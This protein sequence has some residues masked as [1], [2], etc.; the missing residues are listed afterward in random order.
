MILSFFRK[1]FSR[2]YDDD[3]YTGEFSARGERE[4][5]GILEFENGQRYHFYAKSACAATLVYA[6]AQQRSRLIFPSRIH[7]AHESALRAHVRV[8]VR[9]RVM[10]GT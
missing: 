10:V 7:R 8:F 1:N 6:R 9:A 4:G 5:K 2:P 3:Y